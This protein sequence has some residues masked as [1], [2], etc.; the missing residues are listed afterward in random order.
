[1]LRLLML[2]FLSGMALIFWLVVSYL[3]VGMAAGPLEGFA[4]AAFGLLGNIKDLLS[5]PLNLNI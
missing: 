4:I 3:P 2:V 1:M 5:G